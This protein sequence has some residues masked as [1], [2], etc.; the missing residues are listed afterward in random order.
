MRRSILFAIAVLLSAV[1]YAQNSDTLDVRVIKT[2]R[3]PDKA[4]QVYV[5]GY[6]KAGKRLHMGGIVGVARTNTIVATE[7]YKLVYIARSGFV[8]L[9][10]GDRKIFGLYYT[11]I[12]YI[13]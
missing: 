5:E 10:S 8:T 11:P 4:T 3:V 1:S 7:R 13:D 6:D 12:P 2:I 9:I